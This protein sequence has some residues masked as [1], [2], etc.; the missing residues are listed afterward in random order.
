MSTRASD[1]ASPAVDR[2]GPGLA[3]AAPALRGAG[4][5]TALRRIVAAVVALG[6]TVIL[7]LA[8][9]LDPAPA[10]LGTH[11]QLNLPACGW[12]AVAEL[13][14]PTCGMTTAFAHAADGRFLASAATQPLGFVLALVTAMTLFVATYVALTGSPI[15]GRFTKLWTPRS[16]WLLAGAVVVAWGYKI[17]TYRGLI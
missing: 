4:S 2:P 9:W 14:C 15:A 16:G 10:G 7:G 12:I 17:V 1:V 5:S 13:P 3:V 11:E 8:A 6:A